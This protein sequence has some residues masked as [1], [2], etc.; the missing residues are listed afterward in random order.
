MSQSSESGFHVSLL[1]KDI[2]IHLSKTKYS[3]CLENQNF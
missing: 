1:E 3:L 2:L